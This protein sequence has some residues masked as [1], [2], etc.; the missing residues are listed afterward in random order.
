MNK[1]KDLKKSK[2]KKEKKGPK[3]ISFEILLIKLKI[4]NLKDKLRYYKD[5]NK[6]KY[7]N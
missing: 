2:K 1:H 6:C 7:P 4:I 3:N 5:I